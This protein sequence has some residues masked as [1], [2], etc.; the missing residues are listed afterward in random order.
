MYASET[1]VSK[2]KE[3][4]MLSIRER[5]ILSKIYGANKEGKEWKIR[6]NQELRNMYGEIKRK[7]LEWFGHVMR[8]EEKRMVERVFEGHPGGRRKTGRPRKRW[9]DDIEGDP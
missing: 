9:L 2:E 3:I 7:R 6:N 8:M 4:I 5:K 1:W